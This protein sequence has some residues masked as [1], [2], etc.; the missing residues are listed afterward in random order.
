MA[1]YSNTYWK[2]NGEDFTYLN[3]IVRFEISIF[4]LILIGKSMP[5]SNQVR[6]A[7]FKYSAIA[8]ML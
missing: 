1:C 8:N 2:C 6:R 4:S 3:N 5:G 7:V